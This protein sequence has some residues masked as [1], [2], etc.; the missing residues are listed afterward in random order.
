M[1][2]EKKKRKNSGWRPVVE[3]S[4]LDPLVEYI[5]HVFFR[6]K[7]ITDADA[8]K[9]MYRIKRQYVNDIILNRVEYSLCNTTGYTHVVL[10]SKICLG[11][12][13]NCS[14]GPSLCAV[15]RL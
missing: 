11:C 5:A 6:Y 9:N 12:S 2:E 4:L 7:D 1:D 3:I 13:L 14:A 15:L 10:Q 8:F